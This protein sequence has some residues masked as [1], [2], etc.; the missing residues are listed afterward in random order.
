MICKKFFLQMPI[1]FI[2]GINS[3]LAETTGVCN[4]EGTCLWRLDESGT[5]TVYAKANSG[6]VKMADYVCN[7]IPCSD[8]NRPWENNLSQIKHLVVDDNIV[9]IGQDAFQNATNLQ[10]V[11]GMKN[12]KDIGRDAFAYAYS[13][14]NIDMPEVKTIGND[15]FLRSK[16][17]NIYLP[18]IQTLA[19]NAF[20]NSHLLEYA[21]LNES[22]NINEKAFAGTKIAGCNSYVCLNCGNKVFQTGEGCVDKC[23]D[24]YSSY[25]GYCLRTR[26]SLQ[27]ADAATSD[28][29][30]NLIEWIFE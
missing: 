2:L 5:M 22:S 12:V 27:E 18:S 26:Y 3:G 8:G 16:L 11:T 23:N 15:G 30:E 1:L 7:H 13:L 29:N 6:N 17:K 28:D 21:E 20:R 9:N 19:D 25:F 14:S 4:S 24:N 10:T